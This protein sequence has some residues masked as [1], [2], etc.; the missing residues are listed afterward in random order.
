MRYLFIKD[1]ITTGD[2]HLK[3]FPETKML[4]DH[5][6]KPLQG[7]LF[8]KFRAELI[9]ISE[10][11][12]MDEVGWDWTESEKY[13]LWKLHNESNPACPQE[14]VGNYVKGNNM[15]DTSELGVLNTS[16]TGNGKRGTGN[17]ILDQALSENP[18]K[19]DTFSEIFRG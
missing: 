18:I 1:Q 19:K 12:K 17:S 15:P 13:I 9:N 11:F 14:F 7:E 2:V 3:H 16:S 5:F 8:W 6:T 10:D 4:A